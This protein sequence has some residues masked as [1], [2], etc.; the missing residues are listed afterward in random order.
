M[1]KYILYLFFS[2]IVPLI[3]AAF[4]YLNFYEE[5]SSAISSNMDYLVSSSGEK[6]DIIFI[7]NS[8]MWVH[9][10]PLVI[11]DIT[12]LKGYNLGLDGS[13][14]VYFRM[15]FY[16][17]LENHTKPQFIV[18]NADFMGFDTDFEVYNFPEYIPYFEDKVVAN[19]IIPY[20]KK[21]G[22]YFSRLVER[23]RQINAKPDPIKLKS[24]SKSFKNNSSKVF[25]PDINRGFVFSNARWESQEHIVNKYTA[26][27]TPLG[28]N[29]LREILKTSK[30][31]GIK[32]ILV[33]APLYKDFHNVVV[34]Y[35]A[36]RDTIQNVANDYQVP[37]WV[38]S[39]VYLSDSTL[40]FYNIEHM[41][42]TGANI[43]SQML[44]NDILNYLADSTY[45]PD[46][47]NRRKR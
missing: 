20:Y 34:N 27:S 6:N 22:T 28:I 29:M 14:I 2:L 21:Y 45:A 33:C 43:Y 42:Q 4:F 10:N 38:Y 32:V 17:Y 5:K 46:M 31:R 24:I 30:E 44:G 47:D 19:N 1:K 9:V 12:K 26:K 3:G 36:L 16:K 7:G 35:A 37:Y 8:R 39:D 40:Y 23:L 15:A 13:S 25:H 11:E 18:I 41:N